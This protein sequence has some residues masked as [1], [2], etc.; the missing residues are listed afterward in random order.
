MTT[1]ITYLEMLAWDRPPV[2][3]PSEITI[4]PVPQ[5]RVD[6]YLRLYN[7][8]GQAFQWTDR[9]RMDRAKLQAILDDPRTIV[10]EL[11]VAGETAGYSELNLRIA[12]EIEIA[13]FGLFG[14]FLGRGLGKFFLD[15]TL[16]YAWSLGPRRVWLHTCDR[17]HPA[18]LP[19][20]LR[21][22][23]RPFKTEVRGA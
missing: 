9:N 15:W 18:A 7:G 6:Q 12:D 1:T 3:V 22:G 17:D 11:R 5:P 20:Y 19:N 10:H 4:V 21:A 8:V 14:P 2:P 16:E 23:L 13:Y